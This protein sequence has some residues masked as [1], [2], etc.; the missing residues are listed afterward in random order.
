MASSANPP[1]HKCFTSVLCGWL[2]IAYNADDLVSHQSK[3]IAY[4]A[5]AI[6]PIRR[7]FTR[8]QEY[9]RRWYLTSNLTH[10]HSSAPSHAARA[11]RTL[12]RRPAR[13][14]AGRCVAIK[15]HRRQRTITHSADI[16]SSHMSAR[17]QAATTL[18]ATTQSICVQRH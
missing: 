14:V 10:R 5:E 1:M 15:T 17:M 4:E 18:C 2:T 9:T 13:W 3:V 8:V 12:T 16:P 6:P 7:V 11:F